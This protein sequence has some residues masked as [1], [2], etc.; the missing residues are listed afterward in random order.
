MLITNLLITLDSVR[1]ITVGMFLL[2]IITTFI[3]FLFIDDT[4]EKSMQKII[5]GLSV[6]IVAIISQNAYVL[7]VSLFIGGL[8]IA[9]EKF[10][11]SL[12]AIIKA[13][14]E[15]LPQTLKQLNKTEASLATELD[16][17]EQAE[18][19]EK[20]NES[21]SLISQNKVIEGQKAIKEYFRKTRLIERLVTN[22]F[23]KEYG[24]KYTSKVKLE[25]KYGHMV[26]DG[27]IHRSADK[28]NLMLENILG[29]VAIQYI[30]PSMINSHISIIF[31]LRRMIERIRFLLLSR[32]TLIVLVSE[33]F[34]KDFV[35]K[36]SSKI[37][38]KK[39]KNQN[40]LVAFFKLKNGKELD[41]ILVP[42]IRIN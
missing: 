10:L 35:R 33:K 26:V 19:E 41:P 12:A 13:S 29:L 32:Q 11:Q 38:Y 40:I 39:Y 16:I 8:I 21:L 31:A 30:K 14:S 6:F 37:I 4:K 24:D 18:N 17:K 9:S 3:K 34:S 5:G 1:A 2:I 20:E 15:S 36:E 42:K 28:H 27:V 23:S 25:N 7:A 22:F